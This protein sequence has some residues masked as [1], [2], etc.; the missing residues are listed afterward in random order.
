[1][2]LVE[3]TWYTKTVILPFPFLY[4]LCLHIFA[5]CNNVYCKCKLAEFL[6]CNPVNRQLDGIQ[7]PVFYCDFLQVSWTVTDSF[8]FHLHSTFLLILE[9]HLILYIYISPVFEVLFFTWVFP[10]YAALYFYFTPLQGKILYFYLTK[11]SDS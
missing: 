4:T 8:I 7:A 1:M 5:L 11:F 10:F 3:S 6:S 9:E 2:K